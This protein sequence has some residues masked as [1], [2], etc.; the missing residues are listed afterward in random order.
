MKEKIFYIGHFVLAGVM[1]CWCLPTFALDSVETY[2]P[3]KMHG[4]SYPNACADE[5][6]QVLRDKIVASKVAE[7]SQ[8]W[9]AVKIILCAPRSKRDRIF[10]A[11]LIPSK[12]REVAESTGDTPSFRI[13]QRTPELIEDVMAGGKAWDAEVSFDSRKLVLQYFVNEAC[14]KRITFIFQRSKWLVYSVGEACD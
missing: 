13:V 12:V 9:Q 2:P 6:S 10:V 7:A 4:T 5:E 8:L 11:G 3:L 14:V 1:V